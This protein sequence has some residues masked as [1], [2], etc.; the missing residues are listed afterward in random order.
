MTG[1]DH[2]SLLGGLALTINLPLANMISDGSIEIDGIDADDPLAGKRRTVPAD[3]RQYVWPDF[4]TNSIA[5]VTGSSIASGSRLISIQVR[6]GKHDGLSLG[7]LA[8]RL[9][10]GEAQ[11]Y[12]TARERALRGA[13]P[14]ERAQTLEKADDD[15]LYER[16]RAALNGLNPDLIPTLEDH[17]DPD[18]C[19]T[20]K[21]YEDRA[22]EY[23]DTQGDRATDHMREVIAAKIMQRKGIVLSKN[24]H[25]IGTALLKNQR[26]PAETEHV[27]RIE[28]PGK[29]EQHK[30]RPHPEVESPEAPISNTAKK[31]KRGRR[32]GDGEKDDTVAL[33]WMY[34]QLEGDSTIS[35][36]KLA[37]GAVDTL[38]HGQSRQADIDRLRKKF[39]GWAE[40]K[41]ASA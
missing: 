30:D 35:N 17:P 5:V 25:A 33:D 34:D 31:N 10:P 19:K 6:G 27:E 18:D 12:T 38:G 13:S 28:T 32:L 11:A 29:A 3:V 9:F 37:I 23:L 36:N 41:K 26:A 14:E 8:E 22:K 16:Y 39:P 4:V 15:E 24:F 2:A 21:E 7:D 20:D 1:K 40:K